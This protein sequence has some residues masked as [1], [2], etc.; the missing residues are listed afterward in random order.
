MRQ[1]WRT[2]GTLT[3]VWRDRASVSLVQTQR[4]VQGS[5]RGRSTVWRH[6]A[7]WRHGRRWYAIQEVH[8]ARPIYTTL[9]AWSVLVGLTGCMQDE[10]DRL[11][12][13]PCGVGVWQHDA[14][15]WPVRPIE[16][17][18]PLGA[19]LVLVCSVWLRLEV[20]SCRCYLVGPGLY[21]AGSA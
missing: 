11:V 3:R 12:R 9:R 15:A 6:L 10:M 20:T 17:L 19:W 18:A 2:I 14:A 13:P 16:Q 21:R 7:C 5:E 8:C 4:C 1:R